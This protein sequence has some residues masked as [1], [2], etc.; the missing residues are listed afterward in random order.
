[1]R[2]LDGRVL[3]GGGRNLDF[4]SERTR[5]LE[6]N[7]RIFDELE[8]RLRQTILPY[9][10]DTPIEYRWAGTMAFGPNDKRPVVGEIRPRVFCATRMG[11]MGVALAASV[12][13]EIAPHILERA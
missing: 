2:N 13:R 9:A 8:R 4:E 7:E 6:L 5:S 11:G 10:P 1:F 12:A 3:L